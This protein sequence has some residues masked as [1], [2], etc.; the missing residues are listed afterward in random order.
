MQELYQQHQ[1]QKNTGNVILQKKTKTWDYGF[2]LEVGLEL[3]LVLEPC[4]GLDL[5]L[6]LGF[7]IT[8]Q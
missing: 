1:I 2:G 8:S 6:M 7:E 5:G 4:L 3:G